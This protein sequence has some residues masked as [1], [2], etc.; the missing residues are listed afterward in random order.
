MPQCGHGAYSP[1]LCAVHESILLE[2]VW[3]EC[4][5]MHLIFSLCFQLFCRMS[6]HWLTA[7]LMSILL[8]TENK[9]RHGWAGVMFLEHKRQRSKLLLI[10]QSDLWPVLH[11]AWALH[12]PRVTPS[13][14][15]SFCSSPVPW[16]L[17]GSQGLKQLFWCSASVQA[18]L[19]LRFLNDQRIAGRG[20]EG[21]R[22]VGTA[23]QMHNRVLFRVS[24]DLT[25]WPT[26]VEWPRDIFL[27]VWKA[28]SNRSWWVLS[29]GVSTKRGRI[30]SV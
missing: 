7:S 19:H 15:F 1:P 20:G 21:R 22:V 16:F 11:G 8:M 18:E 14:P 24:S 6:C 23:W 10:A 5:Q 13:V 25:D 4:I 28:P 17:W 2:Y 9:K 12:R 26:R 3:L 29:E 27:W 30:F